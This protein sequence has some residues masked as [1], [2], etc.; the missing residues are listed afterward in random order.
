MKI[1]KKVNG[2]ILVKHWKDWFPNVSFSN[3]V[4]TDEFIAS[5]GYKKLSL[6]KEY[7][8]STQKLVSTDLYIEGD[9]IY[10]VEVKDKTS[11]DLAAETTKKAAVQRTERDKLLLDSDWT[12]IADS[13]YSGNVTW[14]NYRQALRDITVD[15][16]WPDITFPTMPEK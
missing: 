14:T 15:P 9:F 7:N 2:T 8:S 13:P 5:R 11:D 6:F 4:P 1:G 10:A 16:D 12:Q 3:G